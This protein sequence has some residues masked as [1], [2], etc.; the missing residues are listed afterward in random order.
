[1]S[2]LYIDESCAEEGARE[3]LRYE[4]GTRPEDEFPGLYRWM[5]VAAV[6][7]LFASAMT[8][9]WGA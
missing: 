8:G 9:L 3:P 1:M 5:L 7:A 6:A 4:D 2:L